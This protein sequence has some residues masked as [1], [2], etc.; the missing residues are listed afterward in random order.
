VHGIC[1]AAVVLV[2]DTC[3]PA[4]PVRAIQPWC[5]GRCKSTCTYA[6]VVALQAAGYPVCHMTTH[7]S[8]LQTF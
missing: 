4:V 5:L 2:H 1:L 7:S 6:T 3:L 8:G